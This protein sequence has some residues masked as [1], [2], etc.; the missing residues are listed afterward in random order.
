M[1]TGRKKAALF[2]GLFLSLVLLFTPVLALADSG[3]TVIDGP[4]ALAAFSDA[5]RAGETY[6][7]RTVTLTADVD[8]TGQSFTAVGVAADDDFSR[9]FQGTFDGGGHTITGL[10][11][12]AAVGSDGVGLFSALYGATIENLTLDVTVTAGGV[13]SAGGLAGRSVNASVSRTAV[14]TVMTADSWPETDAGCLTAGG[15]IGQADGRSVL[16]RCAVQGH[17]GAAG[18]FTGSVYA[19]GL[20]GCLHS[21]ARDG[22]ITNCYATP[23]LYIND[24]GVY[25]GGFLGGAVGDGGETVV[26]NCYAA[27]FIPA[28]G[29]DLAGGFTGTADE[30]VLFQGAWY[31]AD[32]AAVLPN[33][34]NA[35]AAG[36]NGA[37]TGQMQSLS[38]P[39]VL[40]GAFGPDSQGVN[41]GYP[42]LD[43]Q[44]PAPEPTAVPEPTATTEPTAVPEPVPGPS[45]APTAPPLPAPT[46]EPEP[47]PTA[48]PGVTSMPREHASTAPRTGDGTAPA[49][50]LALLGLSGAV[51]M[52]LLRRRRP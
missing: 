47:V 45:S 51:L 39:G 15:L 40:G 9:V 22:R 27:A 42:V 36:L 35:P 31:D 32:L 2:A 30:S 11:V 10:T 44:L 3:P 6:A 1:K 23:G 17:L 24:R 37:P 5:V 25:V 21:G 14:Y 13:R 4:E 33:G 20:I 19:G 18:S 38:F 50:W 46:G 28:A 12:T 7:G 8:M 34:G 16:D 49:P 41:G 29:D 26:Q 48:A 43:W 52:V